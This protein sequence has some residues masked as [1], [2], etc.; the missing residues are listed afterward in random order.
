MGGAEISIST[1]PGGSS[2]PPPLPPDPLPPP[3]DPLPPLPLFPPGATGS[4]VEVVPAPRIPGEVPL[5]E[6]PPPELP[7]PVLDVLIPLPPPGELQ[8][9]R[10]KNINRTKI[11]KTNRI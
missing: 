11:E 1:A 5:L 6:T 2:D 9:V 10:Q 4:P 3:P 7:P 8:D